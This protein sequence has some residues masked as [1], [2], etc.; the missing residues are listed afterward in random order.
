MIRVR[1]LV[2]FVLVTLLPVLGVGIG[3]YLVSYQNGRQQSI[4][5]LESVAARKELAI[6]VWTQSLQQELQIA[7]KTD[8]SP[9]LVS[10]A[11]SLSNEG[12]AYSWYNNL[13]RKRDRKSVV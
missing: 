6:Q 7:S 4:D 1:L 8:Y 11:L 2:G 13:V 12:V 5:R 3:T 10:N 9:K